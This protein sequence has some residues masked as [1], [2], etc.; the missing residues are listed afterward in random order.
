M[1]DRNSHILFLSHCVPNPPDKGE[2]IR[3]HHE[4]ISLAA[5]RRLHL[6]CF[7]RNEDEAEWA[8]KLSSI[9]ASV[10]VEVR[11]FP[12]AIASAALRFALGDSLN[13][14]FFQSRAMNRYV[15]ALGQREQLLATVAFSLPMAAY[16]PPGVPVLL[17][18][19]D[20]D[21]E[22]WFDYGRMRPLGLL[23]TLE[24][25]R[26]RRIESAIALQSHCTLLTARQETDL[27]RKLV[28]GVV[29]RCME[30]GIDFD[31]FDPCGSW[32]EVPARKFVA[33]VGTMDYFPN[34]DGA[35]W[36]A[37][38]I[39]PQLR[40]QDAD[41]EF[42]II[43][44]N[45]VKAIRQLERIEGVTVTGRVEDVRPYL[46]EAAA[47]VTP[48]RLARGIQNKVL[49]A[50]AMG[51]SV[52]ATSAVCNTFGDELPVG[53]IRCDSEIEFAEEV[54]RQSQQ[55]PLWDRQIRSA[56]RERFS[57][58]TNLQILAGELDALRLCP[59]PL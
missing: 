37:T 56:A 23:H 42:L 3:S 45:P 20:V 48:L 58:A 39:L 27:F 49:E 7:A 11:P 6:A 2:K 1:M 30:N 36:F 10:Y 25:R 38:R 12:K 46:A 35:R 18:M 8:R 32:P 51:R 33:F 14:A 34:I 15:Q 9:C 26:L 55:P 4:L 17:D 24:A 28:P 41:L 54:L 21:S 50:L 13:M 16:A 22:K 53:V 47:V 59:L 5:D 43:G 31:Y 40:R 29:A 52:V 57:W 44:S 19:Q